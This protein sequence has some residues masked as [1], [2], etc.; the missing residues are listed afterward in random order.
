MFLFRRNWTWPAQLIARTPHR[1]GREARGGGAR[2]PFWVLHVERGSRDD[3]GADG[4]EAE[5]RAA[6]ALVWRHVAV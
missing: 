4:R 6:D 1:R 2:V 3:G 5:G